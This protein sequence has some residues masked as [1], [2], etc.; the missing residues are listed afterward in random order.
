MKPIPSKRKKEILIM[1]LILLSGKIL[2]QFVVLREYYG[3]VEFFC[4]FEVH[5][6]K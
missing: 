4:L 3:R 6:G 1:F 5:L 2:Y